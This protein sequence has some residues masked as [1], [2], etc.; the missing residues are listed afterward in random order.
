MIADENAGSTATNFSLIT[1]SKPYYAILS[2]AS[3]SGVARLELYEN[4]K[5][6]HTL[7]PLITLIGQDIVKV[8]KVEHKGK[9]NS[10]LVSEPCLIFLYHHLFVLK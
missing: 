7:Q 3:K 8:E 5:Q 1:Q 9:N 2:S 4:L 10:F 6:S